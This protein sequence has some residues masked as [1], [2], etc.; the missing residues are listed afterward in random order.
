MKI[1]VIG[2]ATEMEILGI[3]KHSRFIET[4]NGSALEINAAVDGITIDID[5]S[6]KLVVLISRIYTVIESTMTVF[7][8]ALLPIITAAK[9]D[10]KIVE[11]KIDGLDRAAFMHRVTDKSYMD[12]LRKM[13][14]EELKTELFL[15]TTLHGEHR[16]VIVEEIERLL[17]E[18]K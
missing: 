5:I 8:A 10:T 14:K 3:K 13:T 4:Q 18:K 9:N 1:N 15:A 11:D 7:I 6:T 17:E 2:S 16:N 12:S